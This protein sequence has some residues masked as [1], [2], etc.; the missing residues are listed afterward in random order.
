MIDRNGVPAVEFLVPMA[1]AAF[2]FFQANMP[3]R[4]LAADASGEN[5]KPP[6]FA[7]DKAHRGNLVV[8]VSAS[9]TIE[10][11]ETVDVLRKW[12]GW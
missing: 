1:L 5:V 10:P 12:P 9:G 6:V 11:E 3:P 7:V 2:L 4:A 8:Q